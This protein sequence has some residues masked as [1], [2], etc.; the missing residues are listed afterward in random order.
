MQSELYSQWIKDYYN[1]QNLELDYK[2]KT[3][4]SEAGPQIGNLVRV[5]DEIRKCGDGD[6]TKVRLLAANTLLD[7]NS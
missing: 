2:L 5:L 7:L 1:S 3:W 4:I 6:I